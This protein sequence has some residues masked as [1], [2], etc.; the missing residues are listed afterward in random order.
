M[1]A[2]YIYV[3]QFC[4][5]SELSVVVEIHDKGWKGLG[6]KTKV[7]IYLKYNDFVDHLIIDTG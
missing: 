6:K 5:S 7:L 1:S 4:I 2:P 3:H